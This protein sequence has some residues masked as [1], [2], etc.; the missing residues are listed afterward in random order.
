[1]GYRC[2]QAV[3]K[4]TRQSRFR[5]RVGIH[6]VVDPAGLGFFGS[7]LFGEDPKGF[8]GIGLTRSGYAEG[9]RD[10]GQGVVTGLR[11]GVQPPSEGVG[12][13]FQPPSE[14]VGLGLMPPSEG[15]GLGRIPPSEGVGLGFKSPSDGVGVGVGVGTSSSWFPPP[16]SS[17]DSPF[18][19]AKTCVQ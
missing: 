11:A 12:L 8:D 13:G 14:G 18:P 19:L 7:T 1:M 17:H 10:A 3:Y 6:V 9:E 16:P 2:E 15:V 4:R 5:I